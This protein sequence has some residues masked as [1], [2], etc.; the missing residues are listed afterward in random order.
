M[1]LAELLV[2]FTADITGFSA[3]ATAV[4]QALGLM[5]AQA[6]ET[7]SSFGG[8]LVEGV[9]SAY[10]GFMH[11]GEGVA[12]AVESI[13]EMNFPLM[14]MIQGLVGS[15][16]AMEQTQIAFTTL[17]HSSQAAG[18]YLKQLWNFAAKTPFQFQDLAM[19]SQQMIATGFNAKQTIPDLTAMGN[20]L[21]AM[22]RTT[23]GDL[24]QVVSIF[25]RMEAGTKVNARDM[26]ELT[27]MG[28]NGWGMV[29]KSMHLTV[30]QVQE[31]SARG[32]L[33]ASDVIPKLINGF[34]GTFGGAMQAQA[35]TFNGLLTTVKD[36]LQAAWRTVSGP[37]FNAAKGALEAFGN[38]VASVNFQNL[39]SGIASAIGAVFGIAGKIGGTLAQ[40][41]KGLDVTPLIEAIQNVLAVFRMAGGFL[42]QFFT[43]LNKGGAV[44]QPL[45]NGIH[46]LLQ[47]GINTLAQIFQTIY[48]A[49]SAV[50]VGFS[51]GQGA[52][53]FLHGAFQQ[54]A[55]IV[56]GQLSQD[57]KVFLDVG[58]QVGQWFQTTLLP[59][60][61]QMGPPLFSIGQV[62]I[63]NVLPALAQLW[64]IGRQVGDAMLP[65]L[66]SVFEFLEPILARVGLLLLNG[67]GL[68]LRVLGPV[69]QAVV[70]ALGGLVTFFTRTEVGGA[71]LKATLIALSI[72][73]G[74]LA[75]AFLALAIEAVASFIAAVPGMVAGFIAGAAGAWSMAAG[76][77][78]LT[79]PILAV[80]A[81]ITLI[82]LAIMHWSQIMSF[83]GNVLGAIGSFLGNVFGQIGSAIGNFFSMLGTKVHDG[84]NAVGQFFQNVWNNILS[85]LRTAWSFIVATVQIALATLLNIFTAPFRA[86]GALFSWLYEHNYYF[87]RLV[88][89]VNHIVQAGLKFLQNLWNNAIA[90]LVNLWNGIKQHAE[91]AWNA[92]WAAIQNVVT[93]IKNWLQAFWNAEIEGLHIIWSKITQIA[94]IVWNA[95]KNA[96]MSV[97]SAVVSWLVDRWNYFSSTIQG[98]WNRFSGFAQTAWNNVVG[99]FAGV[100]GKISGTLQGLWN[101]LVN[102][103]N[104]LASN[105]LNWGKNLIQQFINGIE[106]MAGAV[107]NAAANIGKS[108]A[109]FLGFHSPT[110]QGEGKTSDEWAPNLI[111]MFTKGLVSGEPQ[112]QAAL[113]TLLK[114]FAI[115]NNTTTSVVSASPYTGVGGAGTVNGQQQITIYL[116]SKQLGQVMGNRLTTDVRLKTGVKR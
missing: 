63:S 3:G 72:P 80:I 34:N 46:T 2:K 48:V 23:P 56:G 70:G 107:G 114:P 43:N 97:V 33:L 15:D 58:K 18:D 54:L 16:A 106:S 93:T 86:I 108:I 96:V 73:L 69:V 42:A 84:L 57:F 74:I 113:H 64:A 20:A 89:T 68:A 87:Q 115:L 100:W 59:I 36:N 116:D 13:T 61:K 112:I 9:S 76:V 105:A 19:A 7:S 1:N 90:W 12:H 91:D 82:I 102:W 62:I 30:A 66:V 14:N 109:S 78:A 49:F 75:I 71:I 55:S 5:G 8:T 28:I 51:T 26:Q 31:L 11:F 104:N 95:V 37:L 32:K 83:L 50:V 22:G 103:F 47:S 27:F 39:A 10:E 45:I 85:G 99:V 35:L 52:L 79:W 38:L 44:F 41:F 111:T 94:T 40:I 21:S 53:G 17:L 4:Q 77:I 24:M 88:D 65:V 29:A 6:A 60:L 25:D 101:N 98:L 110:E 67:I 92:V 81:V